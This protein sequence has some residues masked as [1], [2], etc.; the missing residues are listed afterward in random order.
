MSATRFV[1]TPL[2][3]LLVPLAVLAGVAGT[4]LGQKADP[5]P[6]PAYVEP[7]LDVGLWAHVYEMAN[8]PRLLVL[9]GYGTDKHQA[10]DPGQILSNL[11]S[12]AVTHK[13]RSAII[14]ELN[15]PG[16]DVEFVDDNALR[17]VVSRLTANTNLAGE[18]EA[19]ELLKQQLGADQVIL[20]RLLESQLAGSPFS[21][22]VESSD[23]ARGR[24]GATFPFDWKG[25]T[26]V[27]NIKAN[28]RAVAIK[29]VDDFAQ[30]VNNPV[31][32]TVQLFG[33]TGVDMQRAALDSL[34]S[35]PGLR[36]KAR[37]RGGGTVKDAGGQSESYNEYEL[38][39][40]RGADADVTQLSADIAEVLRARYNLIAEPRQA[41]GGRIA[42][43]VHPGQGG[44][45]PTPIVPPQPSTQAPAPAS[46]AEPAA[47]PAA[48][49]AQVRDDVRRLYAD[50][51]SPRTVVLINRAATIQEFD[52]WRRAS[53]SG[54]VNAEN[55]IVV[56]T[57]APAGSGQPA[58]QPS[59]PEQFADPS[60]L[61]MWAR[62]VEQA[63]SQSLST[64]YGMTRQ[65]S[66]D[67]AR[68]SMLGRV[69]SGQKYMGSDQLLG[70]LRKEDV[71]DIAVVGYGKVIGGAAGLELVYTLET[72]ELATSQRLGAALITSPLRG[73]SSGDAL[74]RSTVAFGARASG[75]VGAALKD[76]WSRPADIEVTVKGIASDEEAGRLADAI[77]THGKR[78]TLRGTP[79][80][81]SKDGVGTTTLSATFAGPVDQ[82]GQEMAGIAA[83]SNLGYR[84]R[85]ESRE[86]GKIV[87]AVER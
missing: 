75:Q 4:A 6:L 13:I 76:A 51:G 47:P 53:A 74:R 79:S 38:T 68:A 77:R 84:L 59:Q 25:G 73:L 23:L 52:E 20:V 57:G 17:A 34:G 24:Q 19:G 80:F 56:N 61:D 1:R 31:R 54:G 10:M 35:L 66:P 55:M 58:S 18:L 3:C 83:E 21:V 62:Q 33:L 86:A 72:V 43:R 16:A 70:L 85:V 8:R 30:R 71:A 15:A 39:F 27:A 32:Y 69:D 9:A 41:E 81:M 29:F 46:P 82:F 50:H 7:E 26:D 78:V 48:D 87:L 12:T 64:E 63:V 37:T 14:S 2:V 36:G 65:I 67:L 45:S 28:A 49:S 22:V 42:L 60:A 44:F 11:D 40:V 5:Q